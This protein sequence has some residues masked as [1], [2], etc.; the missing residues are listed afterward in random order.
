MIIK[1]LIEGGANPEIADREGN[2]LLM[3]AALQG[4]TDGV[5]LL[6]AFGANPHTT[7]LKTF[8]S[9]EAVKKSVSYP[10]TDLLELVK[11]YKKGMRKPYFTP[12][13]KE[14]NEVV[15]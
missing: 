1:Y 3:N 4:D 8:T 6:L 11:E 12:V 10:S 5:E 15:N 7:N 2:T 14:Q 9:K 13:I